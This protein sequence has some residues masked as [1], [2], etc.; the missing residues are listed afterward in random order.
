MNPPIRVLFAFVVLLCS[1]SWLRAQPAA[2]QIGYVFPAGGRLGTTFKMNIGG[3]NLDGARAALFS[4]PGIHAKVLGH[5]RPLNQ[6]EM[7]ALR[8]ELQDLQ[9]K[10]HKTA[11]DRQKMMELRKKLAPPAVRPTPVIAETVTLEVTIDPSKSV[12]TYQI[13]LQAER[14]ISNPLILCVGELTEHQLNKQLTNPENTRTASS[15]VHITL[16]VV[17]NSQLLPGTVDRFRFT[18]QKDQSLVF[19]TKARTL[20]PYLA[21]A[22]PGWCQVVLTVFDHHG[23]EVAYSDQFHHLP[24]PVLLF[25]VP[26]SGEYVLEVKDALYRG[27]ENFVYRIEAGELPFVKSY[28]PLGGPINQATRVE[29]TG[30]NLPERFV[31]IHPLV[32]KTGVFDHHVH[33]ND[34]TTF[35]FPFAADTLPECP[36]AEDHSTASKAQLITTPIIINGR[37]TRPGERHVYRVEGQAGQTL[38][39]EVMARR[40]GSPLDSVLQLTDS[41]GKELAF[42]DDREDLGQGLIT[43]QADSYIHYNFPSSGSYFLQLAD[44]QGQASSAHAYRLRV[45]PPRPDFELRVTPSFLNVK[46]GATVPVTIQAIRKDGFSGEIK[47][48]LH[49]SPAECSL[50]GAVVPA[51]QNSV[52]MTMQVPKAA[53]S[54]AYSLAMNG[55]A[56][57]QGKEVKRAVIPA[58]SVMQAFAYHHLVPAQDFIVNV[59]GESR[60][61]PALRY[62]EAGPIKLQAGELTK[63]RVLAPGRP[64][65]NT[66]FQFVLNDPPTGITLRKSTIQSDGIMIELYVDPDKVTPTYMNNLIIDVYPDNAGPGGGTRSGR[67]PVT[68]LPALPIEVVPRKPVNKVTRR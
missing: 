19:S 51:S 66:R 5:H 62:A 8:K 64:N 24:D 9:N 59:S 21:D 60:N 35:S 53:Q 58:D 49:Q 4:S 61:R 22:V 10:E 47:L 41:T 57:I 1:D 65:A 12:G 11:D 43:H 55:Y 23:N 15:E 44:R 34:K 7:S 20:L 16:P 50:A 25:K 36:A 45:S 42:S 32:N 3:V 63:I 30:W 27:R 38:V 13:R 46:P 14:G 29:L 33:Q 54:Q 2:P 17:L 40:L 39:A 26:Q 37:L 56:M 48:K 67:T 31:Q 68:T 28:F 6:R 18:A 52:R